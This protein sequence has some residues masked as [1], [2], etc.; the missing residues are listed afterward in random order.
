MPGLALEQGGLVLIIFLVNCTSC[1]VLQV[2]LGFPRIQR[3][4]WRV[5]FPCERDPAAAAATL[6][7]CGISGDHSIS[8]S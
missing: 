6:A 4:A 2:W 1:E 5:V 7:E 8:E 3:D